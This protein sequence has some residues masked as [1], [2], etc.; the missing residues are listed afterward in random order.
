MTICDIVKIVTDSKNERKKRKRR[1]GIQ[2]PSLLVLRNGGGDG[3]RDRRVAE[4]NS[5]GD[6]LLAEEISPV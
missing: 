6:Y 3:W 4:R 1:R 5:A 2:T